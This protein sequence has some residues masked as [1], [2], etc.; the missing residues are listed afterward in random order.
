MFPINDKIKSGPVANLKFW[1]CPG[2][3]APLFLMLNAIRHF[4]LK[5]DN[6]LMRVLPIF[7]INH[8]LLLLI[9]APF[10]RI[11]LKQISNSSDPELIGEE[12]DQVF[13]YLRVE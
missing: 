4:F 5:L 12:N 9:L 8:N 10:H 6:L 1:L 2:H 11:I 13:D 7:E 3:S